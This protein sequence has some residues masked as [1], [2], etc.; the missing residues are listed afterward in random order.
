ML[1]GFRFLF[2]A[3]ILSMSVLV[4]GLGAAAI[5]RTAHEQFADSGSWRPAPEATVTPP[6][7]TRPILAMLRVDPPAAAPKIVDVPVVTLP[8]QPDEAAPPPLEVAKTEAVEPQ[9][10]PSPETGKAQTA[11]TDT[12][13]T[14][15]TKTDIASTDTNKPDVPTETRTAEADGKQTLV[16]APAAQE[17]ARQEMAPLQPDAATVTPPVPVEAKTA[18]I[19]PSPPPAAQATVSAV[20][21]VRPDVNEPTAPPAREPVQVSEKAAS[22]Q[23][24]IETAAPE[25]ASAPAPAEPN[26]AMSKIATLGGPPVAILGQAPLTVAHSDASPSEAQKEKDRQRAEERAKQ[27]RRL[28][29]RRARLAQQEAAAQQAAFPFGQTSQATQFAQPATTTRTH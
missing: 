7:D 16:E 11:K 17:P 20:A 25:Q 22:E 3:I 2:A 19:D 9:T 15:T 18:A 6:S 24:A 12:A 29:A 14:D 21:A 26:P 13:K 5:L 10:S 23:A 1:P 27:R 28:A 4:V 8:T